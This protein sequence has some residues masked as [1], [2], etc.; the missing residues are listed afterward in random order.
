ML[1]I[2]EVAMVGGLAIILYNVIFGGDS[3]AEG[4]NGTT[5]TTDIVTN[6][7]NPGL[8]RNDF[9]QYAPEVR[10]SMVDKKRNKE[11]NAMT[12]HDYAVSLATSAQWATRTAPKSSK[13]SGSVYMSEYREFD[14]VNRNI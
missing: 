5:D 7:L 9:D 6:P 12:P 1:P 13:D 4:S 2:Y 3:V 10:E 11:H 8:F 14:P